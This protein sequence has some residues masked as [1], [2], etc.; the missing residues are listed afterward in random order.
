MIANNVSE[1]NVGFNSDYNK[2]IIL[3]K[4][5]AI[6]KIEKN[7]KSFIANKIVNKIINKLTK[8]KNVN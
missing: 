2:V 3:E 8:N 4:N 5:G 7:K 6:T 1:K